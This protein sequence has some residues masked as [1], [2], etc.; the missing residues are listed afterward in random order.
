ME[1]HQVFLNLAIIL[2]LARIFGEVFERLGIPS[3]IG[4]IS[5]GIALGPSLF[6]LVS[7]NESLKLLAELGIILLLFQ[8]GLE[9]D[10]EK[11]REVGLQAVSVALIGALLPMFLSLAAC[12]LLGLPLITALFVGGT[13]SATS[14]GITVRVLKDLGRM[15]L[16]SS[17]VILAAA[18]IDD[19]TGVLLLSVLYEFA[20][21]NHFE[22]QT[23]FKLGF[24]LFTFFLLAPVFAYFLGATIHLLSK[25]LRSL[26]FVPSTVFAL[27]LLLAYLAHKFG[28]PEILGAFTAGLAFSKRFSLP[29]APK[30]PSEMVKRVHHTI[31]P[32]IFV[33]APVFFVFVGL[34]INFRTLEVDLRLLGIFMMFLVLAFVGKIL[35]GLA[36]KG[37]VREKVFVGLAMVPRGEVGLIFAEFGRLSGAFDETYYTVM[38]LTVVFTTLIPPF[39][40]KRLA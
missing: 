39:L 13:L 30:L 3:V 25:R 31:E 1:V 40:L 26:N 18:V 33:L 22:T 35:S 12:S 21:T 9:A 17:Q 6:G 34:E 14:I 37:S 16:E 5:V 27:I 32:L 15:Q 38:I 20:Q 8:I 11:I 10:L 2:F 29:F 19:I 28:A 36:V 7:P 4:E 24:Y 23:L